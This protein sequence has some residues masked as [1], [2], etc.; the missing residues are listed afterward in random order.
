MVTSILLRPEF[1]LHIQLSSVY[2]SGLNVFYRSM[3]YVSIELY[4]YLMVYRLTR[5]VRVK[6]KRSI[7]ATHTDKQHHRIS[8]DVLANKWG[9]LL[10]KENNTLKSTIQDNVRSALKTLTRIH[11]TYFC[12]KGYAN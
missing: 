1:Q 7:Y 10:E 5:N 3:A 4:Q 8:T 9:V 6:R 2:D 12:C 11:R